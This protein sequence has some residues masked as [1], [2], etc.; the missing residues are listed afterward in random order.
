[1]SIPRRHHYLP[2]AYLER[3]AVNGEVVRYVRPVDASRSVHVARK[4][5]GAIGYEKDLYQLPDVP[6]P[7]GS[8]RLELEFFQRVDSRAAA[9]FERLDSGQSLSDDDRNDLARFVTSLFHRS[10][11]R[12]RALRA[13]M[14][15][16]TE[17]APYADLVGDQFEASLKATTNRLLE[18]LVGSELGLSIMTSFQVHNIVIQ[19]ASKRLLTSDRPVTASSLLV[20]PDAFLILP[21][22]PD[23]LLMLARRRAIVGAFASQNPTALVAGI[24]EAIVEQSEDVIIAADT[25][26]TGMIERL[27]LRPQPGREYDSTG[28][29][30]RRCPLVERG[31]VGHRFSR[32][33][34]SRLKYLGS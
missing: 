19:G 20:S 1:M 2:Q 12:L 7:M 24:N 22:A 27:F 21:Y 34:K 4:A 28:M 5:P 13:E 30:R 23:R 29:I 11:S 14:A 26:A 16:R 17:G 8:Q 18:M 32:H 3:W 33:D 10:P 9:A 15:M 6:D 25:S 31:P